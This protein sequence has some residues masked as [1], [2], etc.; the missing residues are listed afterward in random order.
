VA[1][2]ACL[3]RQGRLVLEGTAATLAAQPEVL[4]ASYLGD[5]PPAT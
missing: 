5:G 3:L 1:D 2:R 4:E